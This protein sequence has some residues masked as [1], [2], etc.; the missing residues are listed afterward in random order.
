LVD[1]YR[2]IN[3]DEVE[4]EQGDE[5]ESRHYD[6]SCGVS[7]EGTISECTEEDLDHVD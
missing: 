7:F 2:A 5:G 4:G 6:Y 1:I 3:E